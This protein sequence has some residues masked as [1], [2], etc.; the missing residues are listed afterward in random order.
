MSSR[1]CILPS[2]AGPRSMALRSGLVYPI[3][4]LVGRLPHHR[5]DWIEPGAG[6]LL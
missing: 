2:A 5:K 1:V 4:L 6:V 3:R